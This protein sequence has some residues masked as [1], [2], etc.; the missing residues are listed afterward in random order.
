ML[1][2]VL[3][4]LGCAWQWRKQSA[5]KA[6]VR[7]KARAEDVAQRD[8]QKLQE[9]SET[10][11]GVRRQDDRLEDGAEVGGRNL[12]SDE[13]LLGRLELCH[14][15]A[16][17][18]RRYALEAVLVLGKG[19][20]G[21]TQRKGRVTLCAGRGTAGPGS[22]GIGTAGRPETG[23]C[24]DGGAEGRRLKPGGLKPRVSH[25]KGSKTRT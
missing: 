4:A 14:G 3:A 11:C 17:V 8:P 15:R 1:S 19:R 24:R 23:S 7:R 16:G 18:S 9:G 10:P 2:P 5:L 20:E 21:W 6:E 22:P 13:E 25:G 12:R